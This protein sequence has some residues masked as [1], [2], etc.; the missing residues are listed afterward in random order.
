MIF[1]VQAVMRCVLHLHHLEPHKAANAV[2][3]VHHQI[4]G[5]QRTK[6]GNEIGCLAL[7]L[8]AANQPVA[9]DVLFRDDRKVR[10]LEAAL[11]GED[12][13]RHH[14]PG[15]LER[16]G[17]I[18]GNNHDA[19]IMIL[20]DALQPVARAFRPCGQ[21]HLAA[22]LLL[23]ANMIHHRFVDVAPSLGA[24]CCKAAALPPACLQHP[25][26]A[27]LRRLE[28]RHGNHRKVRNGI[29][30]LIAG[31]IHAFRRQRLVNGRAEGVLLQRLDAG[32]IILGNLRLAGIHRLVGQV[33]ER[34]HAIAGI[35]EDRLQLVV[36]QRQPVLHALV[37]AACR[38][39]F[40]NRVIQA[41][42]RERRRITGAELRYRFRRQQHFT[43]GI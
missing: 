13:H 26:A 29:R 17:A 25:Q 41:R 16:L 32:V 33:I 11:Q 20:Q 12:R 39:R 24:F 42:A 34:D 15:A 5:G 27:A 28:R 8:R 21:H 1:Q 7:A 22:R 31:Q 3:H 38:N 40:I 18:P 30:P 35:V 10:R 23:G 19:E 4:A 37:A 14:V 43:G 9:Q 6:F 2:I 36:E